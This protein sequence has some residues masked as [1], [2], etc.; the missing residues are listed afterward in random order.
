MA[1]GMIY[2]EGGVTV[3]KLYGKNV[4]LYIGIFV[5]LEKGVYIIRSSVEI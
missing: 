3:G 5:G 1:P 2:Q 4:R